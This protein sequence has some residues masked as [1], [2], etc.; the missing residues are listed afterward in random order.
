MNA[1]LKKGEST[2][3]G[4]RGRRRDE[5]RGRPGYGRNLKDE[6]RTSNFEGKIRKNKRIK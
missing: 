3:E 5:V 2:G 6:R 4:A 1:E